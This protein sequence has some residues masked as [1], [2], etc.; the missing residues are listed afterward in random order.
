VVSS[1]LLW[2]A[3]VHT[4]DRRADVSDRAVAV[5]LAGRFADEL[6]AGLFEVLSP[7]LRRTFG[8]SLAAVTLLYQVLSWVALVVEPPAALLIDVR[9]RR[10]LMS[11]GAACIGIAVVLMGAAVGFGMLVA[12]FA[13]YGLGSGPLVGT[14]DVVLVEAFPDDAERAYS[15][16][17]MIDTLG[18]L[19]APALV[20]VATTTGVSWRVPVQAVGIASVIYAAV[21]ASTELPHPAAGPDTE[22]PDR[23][24][25]QLRANAAEVTADP[26]ARRWLLFLF[27]FEVFEAAQVLRYVWLHD[28]VGMGQ[29]LV[30][31]YAV[32]EQVV[33]LA[34]LALLDRWLTRHDSR[35]LL[36]AA[37][38]GTVALYPAWLGAPGI[39][40]RV[41]VGI[42]LAACTAMLWPIAK[43]RSLVSIPGRAGAVTAITTL[44]AAVPLAL[45]LGVLAEAIG[46]TA[47]MLAL[48]VPSAALLVL[49]S[50]R[51]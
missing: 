1:R 9:S 4:M 27:C 34:A 40:G 22:R 25:S 32:G 3:R 10:V 38:V 15:K 50:A 46:L 14:A 47:A 30:A 19:L 33:G 20:A 24:I 29:G 51:P 42:P 28:H 16:G 41:L 12:G 26:G 39:G 48:G 36:L 31:D 43:A 13:V 23:L 21:I 17:T 44:F 8:L 37:C 18:A 7:T 5:G 35:R 49:L 6:A 11:L 2:L 45:G